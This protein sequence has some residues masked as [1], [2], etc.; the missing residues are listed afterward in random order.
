MIYF[1]FYFYELCEKVKLAISEDSNLKIK[2][3]DSQEFVFKELPD[4]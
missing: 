4:K 3:M 1:L 2:G